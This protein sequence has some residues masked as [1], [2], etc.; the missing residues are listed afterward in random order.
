M[1]IPTKDYLDRPLE[2]EEIKYD[3]TKHQYYMTVDAS[4]KHS[5]IDLDKLWKGADNAQFYLELISDII[6]TSILRYKDER[7]YEKMLYFLSHSKKAR[8]AI[9]SLIID[10]VHYNH[11]GGGFMIAYQTGINLHE[12]KEIRM[13][14]EFFLS[15]IAQEIIKNKGL[16]QRNFRLAFDVVESE[17]GSEW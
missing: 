10:T 14:P 1:A 7:Y 13:K 4:F 9:I 15:P 5:G 8:E 2:D 11:T 16:G 6:Y 3:F 12:M 17:S